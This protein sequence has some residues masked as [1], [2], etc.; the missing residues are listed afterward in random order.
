MKKNYDL[1]K[2]VNIRNETT[3]SCSFY[4]MS[5]EIDPNHLYL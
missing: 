1:C 2:H 3:I 4:Y 5:F